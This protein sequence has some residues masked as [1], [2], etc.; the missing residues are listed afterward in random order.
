MEVTVTGHQ[1]Y[2]STGGQALSGAITDHQ[3]EPAG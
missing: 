3:L 2:I 1:L